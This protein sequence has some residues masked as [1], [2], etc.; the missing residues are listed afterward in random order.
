M[1]YIL[2]IESSSTNCSISLSQ[3]GKVISL[4]EQNDEKYSHSTKLHSFIE[5]VLIDAKINIKQLS[6]VAV[7]KGPG[8]YTG[9]RIGVT[10]GKGLCYALGIPLISLSTLLILAKQIK[11]K[12]DGLIIPLIDARRNEVYSSVYDFSYNKIRKEMPEIIDENSFGNLASENKLYFIGNGQ[13][14]C[15]RLIK[16]N[17]NLIFS[18]IN[19][20][21]SSNE[22]ALLSFEK[23]KNSKFEDIAYF[24]PE[25]L[26]N[27]ISNPQ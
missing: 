23:F 14:K 24:E 11:L 7:S 10:A 25:Y 16:N 26:K 1:S 5:Q 3:N 8:S 15:K 6:A 27:F 2:N 22:M 19:S 9:L 12:N 4:K 21:P 20:L 13:E 18:N 17:S